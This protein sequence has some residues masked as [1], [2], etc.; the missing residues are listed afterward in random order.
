[1]LRVRVLSALVLLPIIIAVLILGGWLFFVM[2]G[3]FLS[4][5]AWEFAE[6]M[7]RREQHSLWLPA[8]IVLIW[9]ILADVSWPV[10]DLL[11]PGLALLL[12][13]SL[14]WAMYRFNQGDPNPTANW[15]LS[16]LAG[17]Y[18]GWMGSH[19][20]RLRGLDDGMAWS[21]VTFGSTWLGDS[22]A[23]FVGRAWG[24]HK[25]APKLSPGK[26]WEGSIG[27]LVLGAGSTGLLAL[28]FGLNPWHGLIL[29]VLIAVISPLGDL[30][31][32]MIKRQVGAKD[33]SNIIPGHGGALDKID[34]L[35]ISVT[36]ATYYVIWFVG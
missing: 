19:F 14:I 8:S 15:G 4:V 21:L 35:L 9:V 23:Y 28:L 34:S 13:V 27:G 24:K 20:L 36:I 11:G 33:S 18:L 10:R 12:L 30:G 2:I 29:G 16:L 17:L 5:G 32:S 7:Q 25:L 3:L 22:G 26:T 1:M 6:L 31:I